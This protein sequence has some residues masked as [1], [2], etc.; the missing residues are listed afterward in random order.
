[1]IQANMEEDREVTMARFLFGLN[2]EIRDRAEMHHYVELKD[3]VHM[4]I[5]V[6][7]QLKRESGIQATPNLR[8]VI[9]KSNSS[10][11]EVKLETSTSP[12]PKSEPKSQI[13]S[14]DLHN[15]S[16]ISTTRD[17]DIKCFKCFTNALDK[18]T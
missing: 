13:A 3:M 4:V 9:L 12:K 8:N 15:N 14:R 6:E 11:K 2:W 10:S 16:D 17:R 18:K 5:K 7:Q 1:M